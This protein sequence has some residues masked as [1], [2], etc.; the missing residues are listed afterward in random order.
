MGT[1]QPPRGQHWLT[2]GDGGSQNFSSRSPG[3]YICAR[4][5]GGG[6]KLKKPA[7]R[8]QKVCRW[9]EAASRDH[10]RLENSN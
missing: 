7:S 6:L 4:V 10:N 5:E 9:G 3:A 1:Q 8:G 2:G